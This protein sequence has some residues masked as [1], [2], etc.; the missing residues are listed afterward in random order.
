MSVMDLPFLV[1]VLGDLLGEVI[2]ELEGDAGL[3]LVERVRDLAKRQRSGQVSAGALVELIGSLDS[4]SG[5]IVAKAFTIYFELVNLAEDASRVRVLRERERSAAP[6]PME[7]SI[8]H[9]LL[10]ARAAGVAIGD[11]ERVLNKLQIEVVLTSHPTEVKRRTVMSKLKR[12]AV[13]LD[14]IIGGGQ[15]PRE[16]AECV[17]GLRSEIAGLWLTN[18]SRGSKP[19]VGD[20]TRSNL[21]LVESIFWDVIPRVAADLR[22]AVK[23]FFP[24]VEVPDTWLRLG[25][26]AGGDRDG[27]PAVTVDVTVE[28]LR[29]HRGLAVERH[30]AGLL[31]LG[32]RLSASGQATFMPPE[33]EAWLAA[34][35]PFPRHVQFLEGRYA[36]EPFRL[37][38]ALL[39]ADLAEASSENFADQV[40]RAD[41]V[42]SRLVAMEYVE[43]LDRVACALPA[44][45]RIEYLA[46]VRAQ[47]AIFGFHSARLDVREHSSKLVR[48]V[49]EVLSVGFDRVG[50]AE[51]DDDGQ[52]KML[53][54]IMASGRGTSPLELA[55]GPDTA[56]IV[57]LFAMLARVER[58]FGAGMLGPYI[59]SM[60]GGA[61]HV[62][63]GY[64]MAWCFG[65]EEWLEIVPLFETLEHLESSAGTMR[66]L[67]SVVSYCTH[68]RHRGNFQTV[69]I[70]YSDSGKDVGYFSSNVALHNAQR[71]VAAVCSEFGIEIMFFHGRGGTVAR[72][73]GP[74]HLAV[75][76][77]PHG[78][79]N[80]RIR[81]TE[82][83]EAIAA[84]YGNRDLANRH[85]HQVVN[86]V[87][88][89]SL[90]Q[91]R[92]GADRRW[93]G[94]TAMV[95]DRSQGAYRELVYGTAMFDEFWRS[96]T[97]LDEITRLRIGSRP[98]VRPG[99]A[100]G[101]REV[102]AIPW[103]FSWLQSR[104]N[105]PAWYGLGTG[106]SGQADFSLM[107]DMYKSD[108]FFRVLIRNASLALLQ[109]DMDIAALYVG[110]V[111]DR[112]LAQ[113][114]FSLVRSEYARTC[115]SVTMVTQSPELLGDE[116]VIRRSIEL[117]NPY[118][119]PLNYLQV[120]ILRKLRSEVTGDASN[121]S[122]L[123]A[124]MVLTINGI[125]AGLRN[126]G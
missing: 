78:T 67:L 108:P 12:V 123:R 79:I 13:H 60:T 117:R 126:T 28:A 19:D 101:V 52:I 1:R 3:R 111:P 9:A 69:M 38:L 113:R 95:S 81:F 5:R 97:P 23:E 45:V 30:R 85:L 14:R 25:A 51:L 77:L 29:M 8:A 80:G 65:C 17:Q 114:V 57:N 35:H 64:F 31:D 125:A 46:L 83:G 103:V 93:S 92:G 116:P 41:S 112:S 109:A 58:L 98:A 55:L 20:E 26:W 44:S 72:G 10:A 39:A 62:M 71:E 15:L 36:D 24:G 87:I 16:Y 63:A 121:T 86:A 110:L 70:G 56:E 104:F 66:K 53:V 37:L 4:G 124:L 2:G 11:V 54:E 43:L 102:R 18:R 88:S 119:D 49:G 59:V 105:L 73:G 99:G 48:A 6:E 27:N 33:L 91:P 107:Q 100:L 7:G 21:F 84:R 94:A 75:A 96:A 50:F 76:G 42:P 115:D 118:V 22:A 74:L 68:V 32:R 120:E 106:L 40:T 89:G 34:R 82:Q 47:F 90:R 61:G 122:D